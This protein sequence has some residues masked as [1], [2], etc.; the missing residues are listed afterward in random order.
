MKYLCLFT[1]SFLIFSNIN[2][3][4]TREEAIEIIQ[5]DVIGVDSLQGR[6]LYSKYEKLNQGDSIQLEFF[7]GTYINPFVGAWVFFIDDA[8]P[9]FW[10]HPCRIVFFDANS[11]EFQ[12]INEDWPPY[13]FLD[14]IYQFLEDWEW[15]IYN[16]LTREEAIDIVINE[17]I[18]PD[19]LDDKQLFSRHEEFMYNDTLW[20]MYHD[21]YHLY[22]YYKGWVFFIDDAPVANWAHDC[23]IVFVNTY[24]GN[25]YIINDVW[26]PYPYFE[27]YNLF[28]EQWELI[29][30]VGVAQNSSQE[31][32]LSLYPNPCKN[33]ISLKC[34][35]VFDS[36]MDIWVY[37]IT[38]KTIFLQSWKSQSG[39]ISLNTSQL[40]NGLY[41]INILE[42]DKLL[43]QEKFLKI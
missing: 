19:T 31:P 32:E 35:V 43:K 23:R 7:M 27:N 6:H 4:Y 14:N 11:G 33:E 9:A 24:G 40:N 37:D 5:E 17:V 20:M 29:T 30:S 38:G 12:I 15:I 42:N 26:P 16:E 10:A 8:P 41:F 39:I 18:W 2:A 21:Y 34:N 36:K 1:L 13:P 28:L 25:P 3:Q 22:N